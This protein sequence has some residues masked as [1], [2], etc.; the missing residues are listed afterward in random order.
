[1]Q[2]PSR[3]RP[4]WFHMAVVALGFTANDLVSARRGCR[5]EAARRRLWRGNRELIKL[6]GLEFGRDLIVVGRDMRQIAKSILS[7]DRE[8]RRIVQPRIKESP[9]PV[10]FEICHEGVPMR[11]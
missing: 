7:S 6:K 5:I 3:L 11:H 1:M 8:L 4:E 2:V 9:F 10:H